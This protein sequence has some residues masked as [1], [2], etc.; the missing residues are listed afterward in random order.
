MFQPLLGP[1]DHAAEA[2]LLGRLAGDVPSEAV[3]QKDFFEPDMSSVKK[4]SV[5]FLSERA[6]TLKRLLVHRSPLTP[7]GLLIFCL[8]YAEKDTDPL[9]GVFTSVRNRLSDLAGADLKSVLEAV[10]E[11]RNTYIAHQKSDPL[12]DVEQTRAALGTWTEALL[13]L[14]EQGSQ[15]AYGF[16]EHPGTVLK[17]AEP[18]EEY[19][20]T[21]DGQ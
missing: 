13:R 7:T 18:R 4:S 6:R 15:A 20:R 10:Y 17:V 11:F 21:G 8:E 9:T 19:P 16:Q 12:T 1:I 14:W 3:A 2:L 5:K